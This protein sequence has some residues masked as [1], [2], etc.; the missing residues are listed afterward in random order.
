MG[1]DSVRLNEQAEPILPQLEAI[2]AK[3]KEDVIRLTAQVSRFAGNPFFGFAVGPDD[4]NSS[5]NIVHLYQSGIGMGDRDYYL[6]RMIIQNR[7]VKHM[8]S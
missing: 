5:M 1:T 4:K 2:A 8:S 7:C 3:D 6:L